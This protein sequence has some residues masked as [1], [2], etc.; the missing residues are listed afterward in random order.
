MEGLRSTSK[1]QKVLDFIEESGDKGRRYIE[2]IKF[3]YE[4]TYGVGKYNRKHR[5]YWSGSFKTPSYND[6]RFGHLMYYI[7]KSDN[8]RWVLRNKKMS[9][10]EAYKGGQTF[11][12]K[13]KTKYKEIHYPA[14]H[15]IF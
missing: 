1:T 2:I 9:F 13:N 14:I 10:Y 6:R 8:G 5:G 3:A 15:N 7:E 12:W 4:F 11:I